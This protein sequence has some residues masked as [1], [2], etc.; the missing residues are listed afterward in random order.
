MK[1]LAAPFGAGG[2]AAVNQ[3]PTTVGGKIYP[4]QVPVGVFAS[5]LM[6]LQQLLAGSRARKR[7]GRLLQQGV[8]YLG[9]KHGGI[10]IRD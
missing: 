4:P 1:A 2:L 10:R 3:R 8:V 5:T 9:G 7:H 6:F